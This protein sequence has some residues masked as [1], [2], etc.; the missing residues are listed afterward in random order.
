MM[1]SLLH[2]TL[3]QVE[4]HGLLRC[5]PQQQAPGDGRARGAS[6]CTLTDASVGFAV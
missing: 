6:L 3:F 5:L 4:H 2:L 1:K